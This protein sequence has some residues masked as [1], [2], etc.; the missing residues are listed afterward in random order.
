MKWCHFNLPTTQAR[1][2]LRLNHFYF[3]ILSYC[4]TKHYNSGAPVLIPFQLE[5]LFGVAAQSLLDS[6]SLLRDGVPLNV[7]GRWISNRR[8]NCF[9]VDEV[10]GHVGFVTKSIRD[11][12]LLVLG[13]VGIVSCWWWRAKW[14]G[15]SDFVDAEIRY[16][17]AMTP[18][19]SSLSLKVETKVWFADRNDGD[20]EGEWNVLTGEDSH[21]E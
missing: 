21:D 12:A 10:E 11:A 18:W 4:T 3:K 16:P 9:C 7:M 8:W 5:K 2:T 13:D 17:L 19:F 15:D 20:D 6:I 14:G 1:T